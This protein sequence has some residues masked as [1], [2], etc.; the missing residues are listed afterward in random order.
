MTFKE[1]NKRLE[2][3]NNEY[4]YWLNEKEIAKTF[5]LPK[6]VS[7]DLE[8]VDGGNR[9]DRMLK[10][11]EI[12]EEKQIDETLD[13]IFKR[14]QNIM[15]WISKELKRMKKYGEVVSLIVQLKENTTIIDKDTHEE[16]FLT[17]KEIGELSNFDKDYCRRVYRLY[18]KV[19]DIN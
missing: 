18:K 7:T 11:V 1:A 8:R 9:Q 3:L 6:S 14:R 2:E 12:L 13:Y 15:D 4:D 5:V 19:R 10:Y 16:R 17:W